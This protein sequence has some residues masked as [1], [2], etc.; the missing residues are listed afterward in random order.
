MIWHCP[1]SGVL[2]LCSLHGRGVLVPVPSEAWHLIVPAF[3]LPLS[4]LLRLSLL[5]TGM[6]SFIGIPWLWVT[7]TVWDHK[8]PRVHK[9]VKTWLGKIQLQ[10]TLNKRVFEK[11]NF[12]L[13][14]FLDV[15]GC[16]YWQ[17]GGVTE[18]HWPPECLLSELTF[19]FIMGAFTEEPSGNTSIFFF[20]SSRKT[21]ALPFF[22]PVLFQN[23]LNENIDWSL[24]RDF[25]P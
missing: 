1:L 14:D 24:H 15:T 23:S 18:H 5:F 12:Y 22:I 10:I 16:L 11:Q 20:L 19:S 8:I 9:F 2:L 25:L 17:A 3:G 6:D 7:N 13:F 4:L 21:K